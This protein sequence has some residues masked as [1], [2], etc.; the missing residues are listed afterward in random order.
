[1]TSSST[2]ARNGQQPKC[3]TIIDEWTREC[4]AID[5]AGGI[6]SARVIEVLAQLVSGYQRA[7]VLARAGLIECATPSALA[8]A[9]ALFGT[10]RVSFC[11]D[12]WM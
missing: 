7:D 2:R 1:M 9:G 12:H 11:L 3:L 6:R 8:L 10:E 4:L 5:V